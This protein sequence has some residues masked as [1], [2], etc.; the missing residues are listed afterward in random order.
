MN[1][2]KKPV[3]TMQRINDMEQKI[4][5]LLGWF[6]Q[7]QQ[8]SAQA[9][10]GLEYVIQKAMAVEQSYASIAK[11]ITALVAE[12]V[13]EKVV[14]DHKI[15]DRIRKMDE[16]AEKDR[17]QAML[18]Q[19]VIKPAEEVGD[20]S[21]VAIKQVIIETS[22][23]K[24]KREVPVGDYR[25]IEVGAPYTP[26]ATREKLKGL[27]TGCT[28]EVNKEEKDGVTSVLNATVLEIYNLVEGERQGEEGT[29]PEESKDA[30]EEK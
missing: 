20:M 8:N 24:G 5:Q 23:E 14:D 7:L 9:Q 19:K 28:V 21:L 11:T 30:P 27:K 12:L 16:K 17:I 15:L 4:G 25:L 1:D 29:S 26:E 6:G 13:E 18:E 22:E 2:S 3:N 10:Q